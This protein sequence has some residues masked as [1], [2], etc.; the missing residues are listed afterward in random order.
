MAIWK[1]LF[2]DIECL[3]R[4]RTRETTF[5]LVAPAALANLNGGRPL[6][7]KNLITQRNLLSSLKK[8]MVK[9][10]CIKWI[11]DARAT[12]QILLTQDGGVSQLYLRRAVHGQS[13]KIKTARACLEKALPNLVKASE[14]LIGAAWRQANGESMYGT[15]LSEKFSKN[16]PAH[17]R[18][19][20]LKK[21]G[22]LGSE[23]QGGHVGDVLFFQSV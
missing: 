23:K 15:Y 9:D 10:D 1:T 16:I 18:A 17:R 20:L 5:I 19:R 7:A 3:M 2:D 4:E 11:D 6:N 22:R 8:V 21:M 14:W 13:T 12:K